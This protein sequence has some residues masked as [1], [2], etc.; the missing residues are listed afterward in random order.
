MIYIKKEK[1]YLAF[2]NKYSFIFFS[3]FKFGSNI[4]LR[5]IKKVCIIKT[6][7]VENILNKIN[8]DTISDSDKDKFIEKDLFDSENYKKI[9]KSLVMDVINDRQSEI[10]N[11]I[12]KKMILEV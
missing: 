9:S 3:E 5:D 4:I 11:L 2:F 1:S 12:Y 7:T 10:I 8:F 6:K